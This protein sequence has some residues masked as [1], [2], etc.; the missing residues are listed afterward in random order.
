MPLTSLVHPS[1]NTC[2]SPWNRACPVQKAW[3]TGGR[4]ERERENGEGGEGEIGEE[5]TPNREGITQSVTKVVGGQENKQEI[6]YK[7]RK[8]STHLGDPHS[9]K[10]DKHHI[11]WASAQ[12]RPLTN[13]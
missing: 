1:G 6:D 11:S 7:H 5:E 12:L 8:Y 2:L 3:S 9:N 10:C 13:K 4:E